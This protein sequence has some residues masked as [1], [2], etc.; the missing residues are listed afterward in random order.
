MSFKMKNFID[1]LKDF[2]ISGAALSAALE[3]AAPPQAQ[4]IL[5]DIETLTNASAEKLG[6]LWSQVNQGPV[7]L[8]TKEL[9]EALKLA[10]QVVTLDL[11]SK[12]EPSIHLYIEDGELMS[13]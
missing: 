1:L 2:P 12:S 13:S 4:W 3:M 7:E 10:E 9:C 11:R 5:S 6:T 8:Q